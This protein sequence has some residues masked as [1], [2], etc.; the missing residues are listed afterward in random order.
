MIALAADS[1]PPPMDNSLMEGANND[2]M[3]VTASWRQMCL[4]QVSVRNIQ[5]HIY[6]PICAVLTWSWA[7]NVNDTSSSLHIFHICKHFLALYCIIKDLSGGRQSSPSHDKRF[8]RLS[9]AVTHIS[10]GSRRQAPRTVSWVWREMVG[11]RKKREVMQPLPADDRWH[12][13][14]LPA[15]AS[16][17][18][19]THALLSSP[20]VEEC[21]ESCGWQTQT[22]SHVS[23]LCGIWQHDCR[24]VGSNQEKVEIEKCSKSHTSEHRHWRLSHARCCHGNVRNDH[25]CDARDGSSLLTRRQEWR[26]EVEEVHSTEETSI[27]HF[28]LLSQNVLDA[29]RRSPLSLSVMSISFLFRKQERN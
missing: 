18:L 23:C 19:S 16:E 11:V 6:N 26:E 10:G 12:G 21:E 24:T 22:D 25:L 3:T 28:P 5:I 20:G 4:D 13:G 7:E 1:K 29:C 14:H 27:N 9:A 15:Q 2:A 8:V 17:P